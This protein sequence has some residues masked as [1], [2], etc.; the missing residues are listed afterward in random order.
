[1]ER[2]PRDRDESII[3]KKILAMIAVTGPLAA[4]TMLP[5]FFMHVENFIQA[6]TILFMSLAFFEIMMFQVIR[7]DYGLK[8]VDNKYLI[9][10]ML[11][12]SLS[13]MV[14]LYT[15]L[16]N[17]FGVVPLG[18]ESWGYIVGGLA[19]FT[20]IE[21]LYRRALSRRYGDRM[22]EFSEYSG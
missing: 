19:V 2:S 17:L 4:I 7:R 12:A 5:L 15:P 11:F 13:H 14:V 9:A 21:V 10:G 8:L 1:M 16:S 6:Q 22:N 3:D 20:T 18:L